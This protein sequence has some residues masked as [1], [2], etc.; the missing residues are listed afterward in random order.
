MFTLKLAFRYLAS[1]KTRSVLTT[2]AIIFGVMIIFGLN[3]LL[4][5]FVK[6]FQQSIA[7]SS[8]QVDLS[9]TSDTQGSFDSTLVNKV[10]NISGIDQATPL[11]VRPIIIPPSQSPVNKEGQPVSNFKLNGIDPGTID[12]V[13]PL[14]VKKGRALSHADNNRMLISNNLANATGL[15]VGDTFV[16]PSGTGQVEFS[17]VGLVDEP[18]IPGSENLYVPLK[19]AQDLLSQEGKINVIEAKFVDGAKREEVRKA[20]LDALDGGFKLGGVEEGSEFLASIK[21][22]QAIFNVLGILALTM[23]GFI[24]FNTFR[25]I[26]AERRRDIA[27]L[28]AVGATRKMILGLILAESLLQGVIGTAIGMI[29]G[30]AMAVGVTAALRSLYVSMLHLPVGGP[31]FSPATYLAAIGLGIG[32]SVLSGLLPAFQAGRVSPLQVMW[33]SAV[34]TR[35]RAITKSVVVG[36]ALIVIAVLGLISGNVELASLGAILFLIGLVL[37]GPALVKPISQVFGRL[38][39]AVF[40]R[41]GQIAKGNLTRHTRRS[42]ITASAVMIG[43]AIIIAAVGMTTSVSSGYL[44]YLDKS[45]HADYILMPQSM[46]LGGGNVGA[47]PDLVKR[48]REVPGVDAVTTIRFAAS[49]TGKADIQI[50]GIDPAGYPTVSGLDFSSGNPDS[51]YSALAHGRAMIVNGIFASQNGIK[52]GQSLTLKTPQGLKTYRVAGVGM[53]YLNAKLATGYISQDNL[54]RDFNETADLLIMAD[55]QEG[56]NKAEVRAS[57]QH[58]VR[59]YPAFTLFSGE[60]FRENAMKML[61]NAFLGI[62]MILLV[63]AIPSF[64]AL[65][66]TLGINVLERTREIG[67][68]RAIGATRRQVGNL[69]VAESLLL[70][71]IGIAFGIFS[72]LWLSYILVAGLEVNGLKFPY[73]FPYWGI[74]LTIATGIIL[75]VVAALGLSLIHITDPTRLRRIEQ[76]D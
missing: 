24:I 54:K 68:L 64:I 47:G 33:E 21:L 44:A 17:I 55:R 10:L 57:L 73:F 66:N 12:Q 34:E 26:V 8:G 19:D 51:A 6:S 72:G 43:L 40:T 29:A 38:L 4:P 70:S 14:R 13:R 30:Y 49:K 16:L 48:I 5:S 58:I 46:L 3:G 15:K 2:L 60:E 22:G 75:G 61:N 50:L 69:I 59:S 56:S 36:A 74:L 1:R 65:L 45:M 23:G 11:L 25:T 27:M 52:V 28:R 7:I 9:I 41:E 35:D 32:V 18:P 20:V 67:M 62:D 76:A 31:V 63:L 42:A 39:V 71:A 53:D 37:T